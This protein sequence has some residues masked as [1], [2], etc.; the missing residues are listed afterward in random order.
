MWLLCGFISVQAHATA[1]QLKSIT[2]T[3]G[4]RGT[5][6][7]AS[8]AGDRLQDT[9]EVLCYEPGI[10]TLQLS[11]VSNK[12]VKA[13]LKILP[14]CAL[15][16]HHFRLRTATGVS[17]LRTFFV[18]AFQVVDEAEPDN[19]PAQAQKVPLNTTVAGVIKS[20][21]VDCFAVEV[22][23]GQRLSVEVE[24][25]R[26]GRSPFDPRLSVLAPDGSTLAE[27]DDTW[28]AMQDPF[29]SLIAPEDGTCTI[30]LWD[31]AY[32]GSEDFRYRIH[33]GSFPRPTAVF[34]PGGKAGETL[35]LTFF[36]PAPDEFPQ[37][38]KLPDQPQEKF[39]VF[40]ELEGLSAPS[41]N[42]IRVSDFPNVLAAP[43]NH[44]RA[45]ATPS[46]QPPPLAFNGILSHPGQEDWFRFQAARGDSLA[47]SVY[48]RR[49]RSSLDSV[50]EILDPTGRSLASNDDVAGADSSLTF[51][52]PETT[53]Y[54]VRLRDLLGGGG[55]EF[56]YRVEVTP[57]E[58]TLTVKIPEVARNDTQS[59]QAMSVPR[60]NLFATLISAKRANFKSELALGIQDLPP[61]VTL[62]A[63][64]MP[65]NVETF[66][67]VFE[68]AP[69][70][71]LGAKL[72][73]LT[74]TGTN[75]TNLVV[76]KFK[77]NVDLVEGPNNTSL[78]STTVGK[79]CVAV[80]KEAPFKLR[81]IEP[82]VPLVQS[83]GMQLVISAERAPGFDEPIEVQ[84][85][86]NPPGV[87]SQ[88]EAT[89]PKGASNVLYQ[90]NAGG[91]A[92]TRVWKLAVLGH[93][94]VDDGQVYVSSP[95]CDLEVATPFLSGKIET[96]W[97]NPGKSG[98]LTVSLQQAKP[99]DGKAS[100]R[101]CGLP[102]K[103][104]AQSREITKDD[105][106]AVFEVT[107]AAACA[108]STIKN[109]FCAVEVTQGG[110][111]IPHNIAQGGI[112]RVT[113]PKKGATNVTAAVRK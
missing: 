12:A 31:A 20:E 104:T 61:G 107:V 96:V 50:L 60:G 19:T 111:T 72:L 84:M 70:A 8:F 66:P 44:D 110:Q 22:K 36:S 103:I 82:K 4:Q 71:P 28:L 30:R 6:L 112:L 33:I 93:A 76:G 49:L 43:P 113:L 81:I 91:G 95:L 86:W 15:G 88:S 58:P 87:T 27:S 18:G 77:Q 45:H 109:L 98:K 11:L 80:T 94:K 35:A 3:G 21:D 7:E 24:G 41:P 2:P 39:G 38:I 108:P 23:K 9:E 52:P 46:S 13:R 51:K 34:P 10:E 1:P 40:A 101:L 48:A 73:D 25:I 53:N 29:V 99:F 62:H 106:E 59:R 83:G 89:I 92:E 68:A 17:E 32:G 74:A 16:E 55:P 97:I 54:F 63:E 105:S 69:D 102:D 47:I 79:L 42:W 65:P 5:E 90:L 85:L 100:L 26:L 14:Q 78:Y 57:V 67:L 64:P 56:V 37:Q 75:G